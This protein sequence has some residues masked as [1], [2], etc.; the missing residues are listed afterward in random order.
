[1]AVA[2]QNLDLTRDSYREGNVG[3]LQVLDSERSYQQ[4]KLGYVR[5]QAQRL[6]DTAQLFVALGG[7]ST[8]SDQLAQSSDT[9]SALASH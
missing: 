5:A 6:Q 4:A 2:Q 9:S 8:L 3:V 7:S 1:L